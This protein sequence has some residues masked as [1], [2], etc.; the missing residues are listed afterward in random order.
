MTLHASTM[1]TVTADAAYEAPIGS[2]NVPCSQTSQTDPASV[3][4]V[5]NSGAYPQVSYRASATAAD[6]DIFVRISGGGV[7]GSS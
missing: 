6:G 2:F 5:L 7:G 1:A 3:S 4:C